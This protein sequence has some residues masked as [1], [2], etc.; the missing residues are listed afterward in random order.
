VHRA[1][2][3]NRRRSGRRSQ[4]DTT[5]EV[6]LKIL[7]YL[8]QNP[9]AADT[10]EGILEWWLPKQS[11]YEEEKVV[12][13]ALDE[14]VKRDLILATRSSDARKHYRLNTEHIQEIRR[15]IKGSDHT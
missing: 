6:A 15:M 12:K 9:N 1:L 11:I 4:R 5:S 10:V 13:R 2:E 7:R 8:D 3:M 14:M